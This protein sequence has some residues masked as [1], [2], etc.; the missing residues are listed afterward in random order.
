M[1]I[2]ISKSDVNKKL[3]PSKKEPGKKMT[4]FEQPAHLYQKGQKYPIPFVISIPRQEDTA[5][6]GTIVCFP[7]LAEGIY[8]LDLETVV[9]IDRYDGLAINSYE[10]YEEMK[11]A[12]FKPMSEI[13]S[14]VKKVA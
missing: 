13:Q 1:K 14:T 5:P 11:K 3:I 9:Q 10:M 12:T 7:P 6:D 8:N 4:F 2:E